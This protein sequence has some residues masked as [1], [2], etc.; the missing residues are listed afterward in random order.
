MASE[1]GDFV[2]ITWD[3]PLWET[4]QAGSVACGMLKKGDMLLVLKRNNSMV[5]CVVGEK[6]GWTYDPAQISDKFVTPM[7]G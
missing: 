4:D 6:I 1:P 5:Q 7:L 2:S 3:Q